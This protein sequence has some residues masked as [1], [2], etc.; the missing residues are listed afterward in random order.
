MQVPDLH[1]VA[2]LRVC[3]WAADSSF[4]LLFNTR[5]LMSGTIRQVTASVAHRHVLCPDAQHVQSHFGD[6]V[7]WSFDSASS[8]Q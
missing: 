7:T 1:K 6:E 2:M 4:R 3:D 5:A 8:G